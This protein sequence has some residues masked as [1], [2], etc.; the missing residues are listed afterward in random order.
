MILKVLHR[1]ETE[2]YDVRTQDSSF[3]GGETI[4][5]LSEY[6]TYD[7]LLGQFESNAVVRGAIKREQE[8]GFDPLSC[9]PV[10]M[11]VPSTTRLLSALAVANTP[12]DSVSI[13]V[14]SLTAL[15]RQSM[16]REKA[17]PKTFAEKIVKTLINLTDDNEKKLSPKLSKLLE[18]NREQAIERTCALLGDSWRR[19]FGTDAAF[20]NLLSSI[21]SVMFLYPASIV[22]LTLLGAL[23]G[24][25]QSFRME[26]SDPSSVAIATEGETPDRTSRVILIAVT[27]LL[28]TSVEELDAQSK[29]EGDSDRPNHDGEAIF[30][31]LAPLLLLRRIPSTFFQDAFKTLPSEKYA[32]ESNLKHALR[33][34][35]D[36][37]AVRLDIVAASAPPHGTRGFSPEER[38]LAAE[39]A[40]RCLPFNE[41]LDDRISAFSCFQRICVPSF[42]DLLA[43]MHC[44]GANGADENSLREHNIAARTKIRRARAALYATCHFIPYV[45][46]RESELVDEALLSTASFCLQ[47]LNAAQEIFESPALEKDFLQLQSGCI[48]F[49]A[50]CVEKSLS[51]RSAEPRDLTAS[52]NSGGSFQTI[53][54]T[55]VEIIRTGTIANEEH[56]KWFDAARARISL[57]EDF[58]VDKNTREREVLI[59]SVPCCT[60]LWNSL[61][62]VSQRCPD[63]TG[64]PQ[65]LART[66][67]PWL[68]TW[69]GGA[70]QKTSGSPDARLHQHALCVTA[71]LQLSFILITRSK[72]F[73][74][75]RSTA[76]SPTAA[77]SSSDTDGCP[78]SFQLLHRWALA[79]I[80]DGKGASDYTGEALRCAGLKVLLAVVTIGQTN[81]TASSNGGL[82][83]SPKE[84]KETFSTLEEIAN[85]DPDPKLKALA[86]HILGAVVH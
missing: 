14:S 67:L 65:R 4:Q 79:A 25:G 47:C 43:L 42:S 60:C 73:G 84:A 2:Q 40:G 56:Q 27:S 71:A 9:G 72:C 21:A 34:L 15:L 30:G 54:E 13:L 19:S 86:S 82:V 28:E 37:L 53:Y 3:E 1:K 24:D 12:D 57:S 55:L 64:K 8:Q 32:G 7:L 61:I 39:V 76:S 33:G 52:F 17:T 70:T 11:I 35:A 68:V 83:F 45:K 23:V 59:Y 20:G 63:Q 85:H 75:L 36:H 58:V 26:A 44:D 46:G 5:Q 6:F 10:D 81:D 74:G 22:P 66:I 31:R 69:G 18:T 38:Q 51:L 16:T 41:R 50:V 48:E 77:V 78:A 62:V 49:F 80:Q 29:R